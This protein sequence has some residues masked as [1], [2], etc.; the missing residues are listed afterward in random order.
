MS[1]TV[2][3]MA[4]RQAGPTA[5]EI[6]WSDGHKSVYAT[7]DLRL[8]CKCANCVDEW[9]GKLQIVKENIPN[10]VH[11]LM[12]ENVGR[13]GLKINWSDGHSTGIYSYDYLRSLK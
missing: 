11:P 5:L 4:I 3:P 1:V 6:D 13:Y 7:Y 10:D 12:I 2:S 9:S 8:M